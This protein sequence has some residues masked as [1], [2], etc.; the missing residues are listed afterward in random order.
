MKKKNKKTDV[1]YAKCFDISVKNAVKTELLRFLS[2]NIYKS[3]LKF[4]L[5]YSPPVSISQY[6]RATLVNEADFTCT[7]YLPL[8]TDC[9]SFAFISLQES[10]GRSGIEPRATKMQQVPI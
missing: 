6:V 4:C 5:M 1:L 3:C 7:Q 2:T 9:P 8:D 10:A